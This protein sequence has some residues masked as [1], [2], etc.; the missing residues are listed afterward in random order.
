MQV[1]DT[2]VFMDRHYRRA[3]SLEQFRHQEPK[4]R[5]RRVG[6]KYYILYKDEANQAAVLVQD[7]VSP[8]TDPKWLE[9]AISLGSIYLHQVDYDITITAI[10]N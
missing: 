1:S 4:N 3:D 10:K 6:L 5:S 8:E 7:Q 9:K 2:I